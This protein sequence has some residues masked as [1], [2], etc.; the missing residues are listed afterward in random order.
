MPQEQKSA[1]KASSAAVPFP[2]ENA[3]SKPVAA[4]ASLPFPDEAVGTSN[5]GPPS[6]LAPVTI[7]TESPAD[8]ASASR[9]QTTYLLS[10]AMA[11]ISLLAAAP[12]LPHLNV[13]EA[14]S[15]ALLVLAGALL[16]AL[17]VVWVVSLPDWSTVWIGGYV[18]TATS[19][20]YLAAMLLILVSPGSLGLADQRGT[21]VTWSLVMSLLFAVIA[22]GCFR[23]GVG[24]RR[25]FE[26]NQLT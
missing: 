26:S 7:I 15:W 22:F 8:S 17:Y 24:W 18:F 13:L 9:I 25:E 14:P 6:P 11:G 20:S 5:D 21:A 16:H 23:Y 12:A 2:E 19:A 3:E 4:N 10:V 1:A